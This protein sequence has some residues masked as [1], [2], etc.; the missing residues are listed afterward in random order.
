MSSGVQLAEVVA[1]IALAADLGL[2][3]PLEHILRS[4]I[5][6]TRLAD[7]VGASPDER[8][9]TYWVTL[10]MTAGCTAVSYEMSQ[11]FGDD[12]AFRAGAAEMGASN[13][14]QFR[15]ILR[16]AGSGR[17][18]L[19]RT[20]LRVDMLRT[21]MSMLERIF[22][23]HCHVGMRLAER[24]GLGEPVVAAMSQVFARWDGKGLPQGVRGDDIALA[25]RIA[26]LANTVEIA[27]RTGGVDAAI[28]RARQFSGTE[29]DP[30]LVEHWSQAAPKLLDGVDAESAWDRVV[31]SQPSGRGA[32]T[33]AELD[34]A[35]DLL[36]DY[37]DLKSPWLT[38]HSRAVA[39]LAE[40]SG[41]V[42]GLPESELLALRRAALVHDIG[43]NGVPNNIWDK[44]GP[45]TA[46]DKERVRL[47]AY[48]TDRVLHRASRLSALAE[49]ASAA[50]ERSA[51]TGYP[52][53]ISGASLPLLGRILAASDAYNAMLEDRPHRPPLTRA[54]AAAELRK[55]AR[56]GELDGSAVDAV[57]AAAG[58]PVRRKPSTPAGLTAREVEVLVLA[59]RGATTKALAAELGITPKTA[60]NHIERIYV[61]IGASSRA[62]AAMFA[63]QH[64]LVPSWETVEP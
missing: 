7:D 46:S 21:K 59:A 36:A 41:R 63:M 55:A 25:T 19:G 16:S 24:L 64:G 22:L 61:K 9:A 35:L 56:E 43:R 53:G 54:D 8:D 29:F 42:A 18:L 31:A 14:D 15:Y 39:A 5:I 47:H 49:V 57:L 38:G 12:I 62:E 37:S 4:C 58:H 44:R 32:L 1:A 23:D 2:G 6:G 33:E 26:N 40:A 20:K 52:R 3:Q 60:G 17:G 10:L 48:Y 13:L 27:D 11:V 50:H 45:L 34:D 28:E 30:A 51:G